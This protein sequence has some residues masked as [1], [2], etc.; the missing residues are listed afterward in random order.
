MR[1]GSHLVGIF[2]PCLSPL[3]LLVFILHCSLP[4]IVSLLKYNLNRLYFLTRALTSIIIG[5]QS[6]S[7]DVCS[8]ADKFTDRFHL[9]LCRLTLVFDSLLFHDAC[10]HIPHR[11]AD[12]IKGLPLFNVGIWNRRGCF[13]KQSFCP[14]WESNK[15]TPVQSP[16]HYPR[17]YCFT[18]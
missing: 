3:R 18:L 9:L 16:I 2:S 4:L 12:S 8:H 11:E 7:D 15:R 5:K 17:S 10:S 14:N 1:P 13:G 6:W